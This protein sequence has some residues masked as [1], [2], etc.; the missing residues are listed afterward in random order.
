MLFIS[1]FSTLCALCWLETDCPP[2]RHPE[3]TMHERN[4]VQFLFD[5]FEDLSPAGLTNATAKAKAR[6]KL[7]EAAAMGNDDA[8]TGKVSSA[9][10]VRDIKQEKEG[11]EGGGGGGRRKKKKNRGKGR[12]KGASG[13]G[14]EGGLG[15]LAKGMK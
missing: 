14:G 10:D 9:G 11:G 12:R 3:M 6:A 1:F 4:G 5:A 7:Y 15:L 8:A 2:R 13:G